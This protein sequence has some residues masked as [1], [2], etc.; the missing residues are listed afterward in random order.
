MSEYSQFWKIYNLRSETEKW[1]GRRIEDVTGAYILF[2]KDIVEYD[3]L[4]DFRYNVSLYEEGNLDAIIKFILPVSMKYKGKMIDGYLAKMELMAEYGSIGWELK[5]R[6]CNK[7]GICPDEYG[8]FAQLT[9]STAREMLKY[10][11]RNCT[12]MYN[13]TGIRKTYTKLRNIVFRVW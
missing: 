3:C 6:L 9:N 5:I 8:T 12:W 2:V 7:Y 13:K 4:N 1:Q 11:E 10:A